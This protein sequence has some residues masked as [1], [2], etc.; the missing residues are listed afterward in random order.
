MMYVS[1]TNNHSIKIVDLKT[2]E[3]SN[4]NIVETFPAIDDLN[5]SDLLR[6]EINSAGGSLE[7]NIQLTLP[8]GKNNISSLQ[9][10]NTIFN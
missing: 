9:Y 5:E 6:Y 10:V 4:V 2:M 1:D 3:V 8:G 7:L